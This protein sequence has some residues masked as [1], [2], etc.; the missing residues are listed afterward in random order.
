M[1]A[2]SIGNE[3]V[4][5]VLLEAHHQKRINILFDLMNSRGQTAMDCAQTMHRE[6]ILKAFSKYPVSTDSRFKPTVLK[7]KREPSSRNRKHVTGGRS[8]RS[9]VTS[10]LT[11][12]DTED[13]LE[14]F[15]KLVRTMRE[16]AAE[17]KQLCYDQN[18]SYDSNGKVKT[19]KSHKT[20]RRKMESK[21]LT[22]PRIEIHSD[23][24]GPENKPNDS[25][26]F[27]TAA[28]PPGSSQSAMKGDAKAETTNQ[29][30]SQ[31]IPHL[32]LPS[33]DVTPCETPVLS[34]SAIGSKKKS[35]RN[36]HN[37]ATK[38]SARF[39]EFSVDTMFS[40][41]ESKQLHSRESTVTNRSATSP[42]VLE[43]AFRDPWSTY[44]D[45]L[46]G[47]KNSPS[48]RDPLYLPPLHAGQGSETNEGILKPGKAKNLDKDIWQLR[49]GP[50]ASRE[51]PDR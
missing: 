23:S 25:V 51:N 17:V 48:S 22:T 5:E 13:E 32:E 11:A 37:S 36:M 26:K 14:E 50:P 42:A 4:V 6:K 46:P 18:I 28:N 29:T 1:Y 31:K 15:G 45:P 7:P 16:C 39:R 12:S 38:H 33:R 34:N 43:S 24:G 20:N 27:E 10:A 40:R 41:G 3:Q 19:S 30:I 35:K 21:T 44:G 9:N 8:K 47:I 2:C 49:E